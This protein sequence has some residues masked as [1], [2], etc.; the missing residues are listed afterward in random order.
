ETAQWVK[1]EN[2]DRYFPREV[3]KSRDARR[4]YAEELLTAFATKAYRRPVSDNTGERL[5]ALAE[6]TY[7]QKDKTFE[8]GVAHAMSAVLASPRFLFK[9]EEAAPNAAGGVAEVDEYS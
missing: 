5:A 1:T 7:T 3:S 9:L 8:Q 6:A 4:A 2:Y